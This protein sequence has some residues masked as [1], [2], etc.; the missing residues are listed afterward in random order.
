MT[1][2]GQPTHSDFARL[3]AAAQLAN[4]P[5]TQRRR[6]LGD[7]R[8][9]GVE[10]RRRWAVVLV[11]AEVVAQVAA[12]TSWW[13]LGS[14]VLAGNGVP[15]AQAALWGSLVVAA[16]LCRTVSG[17]AA[18][19]A[20]IAIGARARRSLID[21][22][23]TIDPNAIRV[24]GVG[25]LLGTVLEANVLETALV[26]GYHLVTLGAV[27]MVAGLV[28]LIAGG[29]V[30]L[31][32][33]FVLWAAVTT[34]LGA[35]FV[36]ARRAWFVNRHAQTSALVERLLGHR[37]VQIQDDPAARQAGDHADL[38]EYEQTSRRSDWAGIALHPVAAR[39]WTAAATVV[40][41]ATASNGS[42]GAFLAALGAI[43][44]I[45]SG[46]DYASFGTDDLVDARHARR[47]IAELVSLPSAPV[48]VQPSGTGGALHASGLSHRYGDHA[49]PVLRDLDLTVEPGDHIVL[50]GASGSGKT[51]LATLLA[52][53]D[54][55]TSGTVSADANVAYVPQ[56]DDNHVFLGSVAFN[57]LLG[58][59]WP[60][61]PTHLD[62]AEQVCEQLGLGPLLERMPSG[63]F[64]NIGETGWQLSHGERARIFLAR[65][66]LADADVTIIDESFGTLDPHT[67]R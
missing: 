24:R 10:G 7:R 38:D 49:A 5:T 34:F 46:A 55:P 62:A 19:R 2:L 41:I 30:A 25:R 47:D 48:P 50:T 31:V 18:G 13:V 36:R 35:S 61:E 42:V 28:V 1:A 37:T 67:Y 66:L 3:L 4:R 29:H 65:A 53:L 40:L 22:I 16:A 9:A 15:A 33:T 57:L 11:A 60:P 39:V 17:W 54:H 12:L 14:T 56:H 43:Y 59:A 45:A 23:L 8:P 20:G 26:N 64:E 63:I 21:A 44:L 58:V 51:T 27:N 6:Q 52:G 32:A